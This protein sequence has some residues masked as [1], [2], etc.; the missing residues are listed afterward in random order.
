MVKE[1]DYLKL[2]KY[3]DKL[4]KHKKAEIIAKQVRRM[5]TEIKYSSSNKIKEETVKICSHCNTKSCFIP[6]LQQIMA[7]NQ[8][9]NLK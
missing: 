1:K 8:L 9:E 5:A 7:F 6:K 3:L 4:Y 2:K